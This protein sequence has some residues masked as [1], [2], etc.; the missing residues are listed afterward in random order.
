MKYCHTITFNAVLKSFFIIIEKK[1]SAFEIFYENCVQ[2][3]LCNWIRWK[4]VGGCACLLFLS[5]LSHMKKIIVDSLFILHFV[6]ISSSWQYHSFILCLGKLEFIPESLCFTRKMFGS[7]DT[8][9]ASSL[10]HLQP[11]PSANKF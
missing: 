9:P 2:S 8:H 4:S 1:K 10:P 3:R 5:K 7:C 11:L 6:V